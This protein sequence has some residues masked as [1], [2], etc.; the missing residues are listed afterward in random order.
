MHTRKVHRF[1]NGNSLE[2]GTRM[3]T[4]QHIWQYAPTHYLLSDHDVHVWQASLEVSEAEREQF[5]A[6]LSA[7]EQQRVDRFRFPKD[8]HH[9]VVSHG[10]LRILLGRYLAMPP[11]D[12]A[13]DFNQ[14]GKPAL[15]HSP[16]DQSLRFNLSHSGKLAL[17]AFARHRDVGIDVEWI[18]RRLDQPEQIAERFFSPTENDVFRRLPEHQ[19]RQ[20]FFNCWTRKEAYIKARGRGLSLPLDQFDVTLR[21]GDPARLLATRDD[22]QYADRLAMQAIDPGEGYVAALVVEGARWEATYFQFVL[23]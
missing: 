23:S 3:T 20:G 13:F 22:P 8:R 15:S 18:G 5:R 7:E 6:V 16:G 19:K 12:I 4:T 2:I 17:Y 1:D 21:P 11:Q 14:Y 10:V 9:F